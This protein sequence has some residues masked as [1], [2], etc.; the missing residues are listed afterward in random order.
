MAVSKLVVIRTQNAGV[1]YGSLVKRT[2]SEAVLNKCRRLWYWKGAA[3]LSQLATEG[4]SA[5]AECKF[6]VPVDG[7]TMLQVIEVIP[8]TKAGAKSIDGVPLWR[9]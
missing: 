8:V 5:P 3:S 9:A 6:S 2:G 4:V 1:F 7:Q